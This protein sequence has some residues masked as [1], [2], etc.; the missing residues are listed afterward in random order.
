MVSGTRRWDSASA[1]G[2]GKIW[3]SNRGSLHRISPIRLLYKTRVTTF[4]WVPFERRT[5]TVGQGLDTRVRLSS[6]IQLHLLIRALI[7]ND[8]RV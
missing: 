3:H 7:Y 2:R 5:L 4:W 1:A 6:R 8:P